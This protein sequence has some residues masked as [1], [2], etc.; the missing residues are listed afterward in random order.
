MTKLNSSRSVYHAWD[1]CTSFTRAGLVHYKMNHA[2]N[3]ARHLERCWT[4]MASHSYVHAASSRVASKSPCRAAP[5]HAREKEWL[6][7]CSICTPTMVGVQI[8]AT[9]SSCAR[10]SMHGSRG[11]K[12][13]SQVRLQPEHKAA[14]N[15]GQ[16]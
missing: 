2:R 9:L 13:R 15:Y 14:C 6:R 1:A 8:R 3:I 4:A 16:P 12:L 7:N 11:Y 10:E 5:S